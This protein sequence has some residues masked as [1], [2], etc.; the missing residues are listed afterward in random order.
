MNKKG[1]A[2]HPRNPHSGR[3]D[4]QVLCQAKPELAQYL[5]P[6]P[7]GDQTIDFSDSA[8]V[9]SL[10]A[11]LL[12]HYYNVQSWSIPRGYLCPPIPGRADYIHYLSDLVDE[13][14]DNI[15]VLDIG[16]GANCIYPIIGSQSYG[17][18]FTGTETNPISIRSAESIVEANPSLSGFVTIIGQEDPRSF[19]KGI[20]GK[21]DY[22]NLTMCNPPF[23]KS[24]EAAQS[25]TR[26]KTR[27]LGN[28]SKP[29]QRSNLNFGGQA[30]ELWCPGG[31]LRFV[32]KMIQES[33]DFSDQVGWF[34]SLISKNEHVAPLKRAATKKGAKVE[35]IEMAQ[36]QKQSRFLAWRF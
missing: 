28:E 20:I 13:N 14:S 18:R 19:F 3:Y 6:N 31:E 17:W 21:N 10:N 29:T 9:L 15:R 22:F 16:T 12:A 33:V 26:R 5:R 32:K 30:N 25:G 4:F 1:G 11:A 35:V 36:G 27:N 34:S 2:L 24:E 8:A 23:H 7:T